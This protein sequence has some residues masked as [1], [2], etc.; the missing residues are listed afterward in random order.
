MLQLSLIITDSQPTQL[1]GPRNQFNM[2]NVFM[3]TWR[4]E[5][6]DSLEMSPE[7]AVREHSLSNREVSLRD[8]RP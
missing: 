8:C 2:K 6:V 5:T 7:E 4:R 1:N 3:S